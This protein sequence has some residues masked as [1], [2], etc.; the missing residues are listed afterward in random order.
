M[1]NLE[2]NRLRIVLAE[3]NKSNKWLA[4]QLGINANTVSKWI[5]NSQQPNLKTFY[6]IS[7]LLQVDLPDLFKST[8]KKTREDQLSNL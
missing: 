5:N 7:V 4:E 6:R 2:L 1:S 8:L 3:K